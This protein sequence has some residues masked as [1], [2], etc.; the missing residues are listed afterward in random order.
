MK[1]EVMPKKASVT[2]TSTKT[3]AERNTARTFKPPKYKSF[4]MHKRIK[5]PL[6]KIP[7]VWKLSKQGFSQLLRRKRVFIGITLIYALLVFVFVKSF[8][9]GLN[10]VQLK[11]SLDGLF[12][13]SVKT[14][15]SSLT[16]FSL[17][18]GSASA[19]KG[20][21]A[22]MYQTIILLLVS[23]AYI[24]ALRETQ[25]NSKQTATVKD[26]FYKGAAPIVPF[27]IVLFI[28]SL[29]LIPIVFANFFYS[30]VIVGG[31][32]ATVPEQ[33]LWYMF[34][35][36][37]LLLSLYMVSSSIFALFIVTL[38]DTRPMQALRAARELV[39]FRRWAVMRKVVVLPI[40]LVLLLAIITL[41]AILLVPVI[42]QWVFFLMSLVL[43]PLLISYMYA[44]YRSLL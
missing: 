12:T 20:E 14:W 25:S 18:L 11:H 5:S 16:I 9:G 3:K 1:W 10:V 24:W 29:Q 33:V 26:S 37:L 35:G 38:P 43:V 28:I 7:S 36:L 17:L 13:G 22:S 42:A 34:I 31:Y 40:S 15:G 27:L 4:R 41:P 8:S 39:R 19:T 21:T 6:G 30:F 2:K 32:A 44:L 23:L